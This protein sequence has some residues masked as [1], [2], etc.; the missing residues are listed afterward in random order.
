MGRVLKD[1]FPSVLFILIS[2]EAIP[3]ILEQML[4]LYCC[5]I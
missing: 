4:Q 3:K 5:K 2:N 1:P